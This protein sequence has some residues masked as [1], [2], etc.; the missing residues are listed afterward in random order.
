M[1]HSAKYRIGS[2]L[3]GAGLLN[4]H[5]LDSALEEHRRTNERVGDTLIR[6]GLLRSEDLTAPLLVQEHLGSI[7][8][9]VKLAAGER[10][11][12]GDLLVQSGHISSEQLD[13]AIAEQMRS[14]E[15]LGEVFKR[16]GML[17]EQQLRGLLVF[18]HNQD[19]SN[20]S[21]L[22]LGELLVSTGRI[23]REQ[24]EDALLKQKQSDRNLGEILLESGYTSPACIQHCVSLQKMLT[25]TVL[26]AILALGMGA[27][28][29]AGEMCAFSAQLQNSTAR[30]QYVAKV[31]AE[32][33]NMVA[34]NTTSDSTVVSDDG[35]ASTF[36]FGKSSAV[37]NQ[38][39][40]TLDS[41]SQ[42]CLGC[43]DGLQASDRKINFKN[44]PG[45]K[46]HWNQGASEHPVG[47]NY[48]SYAAMDP[49]SYKPVS[50]FGS[51]MM[52]VNGRVGCTTC[53][54]PLNPEKSHL[55]KSDYRSALC[56]TC[57]TK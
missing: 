11:L 3:V 44:T 52:F 53:H 19:A 41:F 9:A 10:Q 5:Q 56:L 55:A 16:L 8:D 33:G 18:Q 6:S 45:Q 21:P 50:S 7:E 42:D 4:Q 46:S 51:K 30:A 48:A 32:T 27:E 31:A 23:A 25:K 49:Q 57:H 29:Q 14:G 54:D 17:S 47:M 36:F 13:Q 35:S 28:S 38:G 15:K 12:F 26:T 1:G 22:K 24:L 20:N 40:S 2:I 43:H 34:Y 39:S 37:K